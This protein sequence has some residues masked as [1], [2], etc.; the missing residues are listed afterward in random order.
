VAAGRRR[1]GAAIFSADAMKFRN[2]EMHWRC[3]LVLAAAFAIF[4]PPDAAHAQQQKINLCRDGKGDAAIN[5]C[6]DLIKR[7][8]KDLEAYYFNRSVAWAAKGECDLAVSDAEKALSLKRDAANYSQLGVVLF[9]CKEDTDQAISVYSEGIKALPKTGVLYFNRG[10][11]FTRNAE[12]E[13]AEADFAQAIRLDPRDPDNYHRRGQMWSDMEEWDKAIADYT[14]AIG[15]KPDM[16]TAYSYRG[17]AYVAKGDIAKSQSDHDRAIRLDPKSSDNYNNRAAFYR[18]IGDYDRAL[19][20]HD[21]AVALS[22]DTD[23][24]AS[25]AKTFRIMGDLDRALTS[26]NEAVKLEQNSIWALYTRGIIYRYR[27]EYDRALADFDRLLKRYSYDASS[28][29]ERGRTYE[30]KGD[31]V[32]ARADFE[33][34]LKERG[35]LA[36][37]AHADARAQLASLDSGAASPA[38]KAAPVAAAVPTTVAPSAPFVAK[39]QGRRVALVIG[40]GQY[41]HTPKLANPPRDATAVANSLRAIGFQSVTVANDLSRE[42]LI[43]ALR[44][45]S[46]EAEKADWVMIYYAGHGIEVGGVNYLIPVDAKLESDRD[47]SFEAVSLEQV[48]SAV[49]GARKIKLVVLDACRDN[50]F[51]AQMRRSLATRSIGRGLARIEPEGATL[52][53]YAAKHGQTALDGDGANSPFASALVRRMGTPDIEINKIFRLIRDD[54]MEAT[55]GRQEPFTY[56]SLP[57][58][59]DFYF[60]SAK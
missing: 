39:D 37:T 24:Y 56:G 58:R 52:V 44:T 46:R 35:T 42:G 29:V 43:S 4:L 47:T 59:E 49:D 57:G 53:V 20:D 10:I 16:A 54:V 13:K 50:P 2:F 25:R 40:N 15:M 48:L 33:R 17:R 34:A 3:G 60:V 1:V 8:G 14:R 31:L 45:F 32:R 19:S 6:T 26:I 51:A 22:P 12:F 23:A 9:D 55:A 36:K 11:A 30:K 7:G 27:G 5:A 38:S 41:A 18:E 28:Y 21:K